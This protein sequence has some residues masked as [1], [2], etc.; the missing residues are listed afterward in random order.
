MNKQY[1]EKVELTES[2]ILIK[3]NYIMNKTIAAGATFYGEWVSDIE[4]V[5][6][7]GI[8]VKSNQPCSILVHLS[9]FI[10]SAY[11]S[12]I[13]SIS[14]QTYGGWYAVSNEKI[15]FFLPAKN[16]RIGLKND[17]NSDITDGSLVFL[18]RYN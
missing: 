11:S 1:T 10:E 16:I 2:K 9:P 7:I 17:G 3:D 18:G 13:G 14:T 5:N 12:N 8:Q 4:T 6:K 15:N